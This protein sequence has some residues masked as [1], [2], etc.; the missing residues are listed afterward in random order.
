MEAA[1]DP[2]IVYDMEGRRDLPQSSLYPGF[3]MDPGR[4]AWG[5]KWTISCPL[6]PGRR[7]AAGW[8]R[9]LPAR[10][11]PVSKP[12]VLPSRAKC[13]TSAC[14]AASTGDLDGQL[15]GS[16]IIHRDVSALKRMEKQLMEIGDRERQKIGQD[17]HDDLC[18]HLI[19][20]EGLC[21][22]LRTRLSKS[23]PETAAL[24]EQISGLIREAIVKSRGLARGLCPVYLVDRG[25]VFALRELAVKT[26]SYF[27]VHCRFGADARAGIQDNTTATQLYYIVQE[28]VNNAIRH[29]KARNIVMELRE[30]NGQLILSVDDDGRG[31]AEVSEGGGMG[32]A[33]HGFSCQNDF[34][35][36]GDS[37]GRRPGDVGTGGTGPP[38]AR[39]PEGRASE[40]GE[41]T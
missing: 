33:H 9:S 6:T 20:I 13:S 1:P 21:K 25:L 38:W 31:M 27:G 37:L 40:R 8:P 5:I 24:A 18:P 3:R 17:L 7:P 4:S 26:E 14:G 28:A 16:V 11:S 32:F 41:V 10:C 15:A 19:G 36:P 34:R 35:Q 22:V 12:A 23:C 30:K 2:I 39:V 29:G